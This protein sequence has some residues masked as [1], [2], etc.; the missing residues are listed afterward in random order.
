M[1]PFLAVLLLAACSV[2]GLVLVALGQPGLWLIVLAVCGYALLPGV[3]SFG[4]GTIAV[5]LALAL[6]G[7]LIEL[8]LGF[9]L[10]RRY[11]G[12]RRAGWGAL[13]GGLVGAFVGFPV[14]IVGSV[15][16]SLIGSFVGAAVF[17]ATQAPAGALRVGWGAVL[18][19]I[20]ATSAKIGL[21]IAMAMVAISSALRG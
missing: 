17:E 9:R 8:W 21:G 11:G 4:G 13:L 15:I 7:E 12:S 20:A 10:A 18:G 16:G 1:A 3:A 6:A 19:R 2:T 14:P 5:V